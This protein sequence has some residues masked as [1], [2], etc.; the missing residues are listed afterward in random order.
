[1]GRRALETKLE[2]VAQIGDP[3]PYLVDTTWYSN[4]DHVKELA[5]GEKRPG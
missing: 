4:T 2:M 5:A 3:V 1:V